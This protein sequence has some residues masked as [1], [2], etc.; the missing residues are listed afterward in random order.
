[1]I[2]MLLGEKDR[3]RKMEKGTKEE[4]KKICLVIYG[5]SRATI[6]DTKR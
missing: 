6:T 3:A 2:S 1:M 4:M 5:D